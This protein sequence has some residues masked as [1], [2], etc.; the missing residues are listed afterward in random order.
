MIISIDLKYSNI[1]DI[2][3]KVSVGLLHY[4]CEM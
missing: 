2:A 4:V 1:C 3:W